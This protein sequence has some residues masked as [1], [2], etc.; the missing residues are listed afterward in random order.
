[1]TSIKTFFILLI[2]VI[3]ITDSSCKKDHHT[4]APLVEK[5]VTVTTIAGNGSD[6]FVDGP[7]LS[8]KFDSPVDVA[9]AADGI[10]YVADFNNHRIRKIVGGQVSTLAGNDSFGIKNGNGVLAQFKYPYRIAVDAGGSIYVCDQV[11]TRIRR[12][13]LTADVITYAGT[14][15]PGFLNGDALTARFEGNAEGIAVDALGNVYLGDTFNQLIRKISTASQ[16]TTFAGST[17]GFTDGNGGTAQFRYP[18]GIT[19]DENGNVYVADGGN[20]SI[21]KITADGAVTTLAGNGQRGNSDGRGKSA[22]FSLIGDMV[23]DRDGNLYVADDQRIRK[24]RPDGTVTTIAG[25]TSG[26]EDGDGSSAKFH[27]PFGLGVDAQGNVYVADV[28]NNR[29][30]KI[31][32]N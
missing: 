2:V 28:N 20:F 16:V 18:G 25:S 13:S 7:A 22:Q 11:D 26:Y 4:S 21:R 17:E 8:A 1:M 31:S 14:N 3:S 23:A 6:A 29:I 32:F 27:D 10:I 30:R 12:I 5:K 24:I 15:Q 9:V 19:C